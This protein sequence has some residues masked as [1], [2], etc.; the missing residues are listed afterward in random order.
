LLDTG[1]LS[2]RYRELQKVVHPDRFASA[3]EQE[4]RVALQQSIMVNEAFEVLRDPLKRAIYMLELK[5]VKMNQDTATTSDGVFLMQ[6]MELREA[7]AEVPQQS[8]PLAKLDE[9]MTEISVLIK[10]QIAQLAIQLEESTPDQLNAASESVSKMQFLNKLHS[11][12]EM[13]EADLEEMA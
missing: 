5:G 7:L 6:Q 2:E 3:S 13:V 4:Q 9:L 10:T 1:S 8:D 12:A 11:E